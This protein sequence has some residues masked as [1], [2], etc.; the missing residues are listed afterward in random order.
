ML[1]IAIDSGEFGWVWGSGQDGSSHLWTLSDTTKIGRELE[2]ITHIPRRRRV[3]TQAVARLVPAVEENHPFF[4][5]LVGSGRAGLDNGSPVLE[6]QIV[7]G[8]ISGFASGGLD[9]I[10][11]D[12][13][14]GGRDVVRGL[15]DPSSHFISERHLLLGGGKH[16]KRKSERSGE[17][18]FWMLS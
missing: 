18:H 8:G 5:A 1:V 12:R 9:G 16:G 6:R 17:A 10:P 15:V 14:C 13:G 7:Y 3:S 11:C 2:C 4:W